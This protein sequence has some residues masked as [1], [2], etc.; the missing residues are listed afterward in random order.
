MITLS[1]P[2]DASIALFGENAKAR[3]PLKKITEDLNGNKAAL[4]LYRERVVSSVGYLTPHSR[5]ECTH[6]AY[7]QRVEVAL[8][9][10]HLRDSI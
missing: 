5:S 3:T 10:K 8:R 6:L 9:F 1:R 7:L 4:T 2:P